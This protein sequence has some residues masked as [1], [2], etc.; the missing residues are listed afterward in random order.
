MTNLP[1]GLPTIKWC[2]R[3]NAAASQC[4]LAHDLFDEPWKDVAVLPV[5]AVSH[6]RQVRKGV[7][8]VRDHVELPGKAGTRVLIVE[9]PEEPPTGS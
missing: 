9:L 7:R 8:P 4:S 6:V 5:G 3:C 2:T 1:N